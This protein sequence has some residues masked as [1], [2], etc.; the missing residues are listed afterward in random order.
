MI[1][2]AECIA[3]L[4]L[5]K[6]VYV[7]PKPEVSALGTLSRMALWVLVVWGLVHWDRTEG[8]G[9]NCHLTRLTPRCTDGA[10]MTS[11]SADGEVFTLP[12]PPPPPRLP[13]HLK[14][15]VYLQRCRG[16]HMILEKGGWGGG[17]G[18][19]IL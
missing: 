11:R 1:H 18:E 16:E 15:E 5:T 6:Q 8:A 14:M 13:L 17:G 10:S 12:P 3:N 2:G 9:S 4:V 19:S 7:G